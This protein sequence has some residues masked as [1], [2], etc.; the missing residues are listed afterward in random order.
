MPQTL[1]PSH[2]FPS[3]DPMRISVTIDSFVS[4]KTDA[5]LL[6]FICCFSCLCQQGIAERPRLKT[7]S[8]ALSWWVSKCDRRLAGTEA[9]GNALGMQTLRS[10]LD[11]LN[12][13]LWEWS[14]AR[15]RCALL[16][17]S[18]IRLFLTLWTVARQAALSM[19]FSRQ[20][21]RS[22]LPFPSLKDLPDPGIQ[23]SSPALQADSLSNEPPPPAKSDAI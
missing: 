13:E 18:R 17:V 11:P 21:H 22:G 14:P 12:R 20:E 9:S 1:S 8:C 5:V 7:K 15:L 23:P 19:G 2:Y 4:G 16:V 3:N 10:H 6:V